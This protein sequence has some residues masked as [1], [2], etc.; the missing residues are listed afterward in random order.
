MVKQFY[1]L[2]HVEVQ[3]GEAQ[4]L[5]PSFLISVGVLKIAPLGMSL[6]WK[7]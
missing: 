6:A 1:N 7:G 2:C 4:N 3:G 5:A